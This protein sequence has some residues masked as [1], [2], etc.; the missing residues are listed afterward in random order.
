MVRRGIDLSYELAAAG[1]RHLYHL[2]RL[3]GLQVYSSSEDGFYGSGIAVIG[4]YGLPVLFNVHFARKIAEAQKRER[5]KKSR[6]KASRYETC[7]FCGP[8]TNL[9]MNMCSGRSKQDYVSANRVLLMIS[10]IIV[11]F[12]FSRSM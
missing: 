11:H 6:K 7:H 10:N 12:I 2:R 8:I 4:L 9:N 5:E 1:K 3:H